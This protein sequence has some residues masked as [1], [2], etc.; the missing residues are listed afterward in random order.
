[1]DEILHHFETMANHRLFGVYREILPELLGCEMDFVHIKSFGPWRIGFARFS[2]VF[3]SASLPEVQPN[4]K[5]FLGLDHFSGK[6]KVWSLF[7][8]AIH[9]AS[10]Q[11]SLRPVLELLEELV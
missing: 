3:L 2:Q 4:F 8:V 7:W 9:S 5:H 11:P 1:M 10:E 6:Y